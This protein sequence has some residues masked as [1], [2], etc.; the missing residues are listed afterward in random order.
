MGPFED[1]FWGQS[2]ADTAL[3][4]TLVLWHVT[5]P[6]FCHNALGKVAVSVACRGG[7][8]ELGDG[9]GHP[10]QGASKEWNYKNL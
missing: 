2:W 5:I 7:R 4:P 9:P 10:C 8:G 3:C 1:F 6:Q